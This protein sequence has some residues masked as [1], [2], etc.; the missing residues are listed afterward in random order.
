MI[1]DAR[2][3]HLNALMS[4]MIASDMKNREKMLLESRYLLP[5]KKKKNHV[6]ILTCKLKGIGKNIA[7]FCIKNTI[8]KICIKNRLMILEYWVHR[9]F[10][11]DEF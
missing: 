2:I 10:M 5:K 11:N 4:S 7:I 3:I 9:F 1:T 6:I 8:K